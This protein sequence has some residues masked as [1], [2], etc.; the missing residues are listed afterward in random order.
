[1]DLTVDGL[2]MGLFWAYLSKPAHDS[3]CPSVSSSYA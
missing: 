1:M 2:L 3:A